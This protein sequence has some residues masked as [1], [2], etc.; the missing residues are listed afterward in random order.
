MPNKYNYDN[1]QT[2]HSDD[3][4]DIITI[5]PPWLLR[6]GI[7]LF[8]GILVLIVGL[9]AFIRYPDIVKTQLQ[10]DSSNPPKP[11]VAKTA[12]K[13]LQL[14][15]TQNETVKAGQQ[16]ALIESADGNNKYALIAPQAGKVAFAG[17]VQPD[18]AVAVNQELFYIIPENE[19]FY[20]EMIIPQDNMGKIQAGQQVLIK[21]KAYP[22]QGIWPGSG[23]KLPT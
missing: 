22:F 20:G 1:E 4:Q 11:V 21:L 10:I 17:I 16:L 12:G 7:S 5:V 13:V 14:L 15:V 19:A 2:R 8:F 3:M 6:W 18:Q 9:T 23:G